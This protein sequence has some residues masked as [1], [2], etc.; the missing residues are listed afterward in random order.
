MRTINITTTILISIIVTSKLISHPNDSS[1]VL[2]FVLICVYLCSFLRV[3]LLDILSRTYGSM[4]SNVDTE[5]K[6]DNHPDHINR[7]LNSAY[8]LERTTDDCSHTA[9]KRRKSLTGTT[10]T[11][12]TNS[13]DMYEPDALTLMLFTTSLVGYL[14][15]CTHY[16]SYAYPM[17]I[18]A[19]VVLSI[20]VSSVEE[21][22]YLHINDKKSYA[23]Y[24]ISF[25]LLWV[26]VLSGMT[27]TYKFVGTYN[28]S[29]LT[30]AW[31]LMYISYTF[32]ISSSTL[33]AP[34]DKVDK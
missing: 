3:F 25:T 32:G 26:T 13:R 4:I 34:V 23:L 33:P 1:P 22:H 31:I 5:G 19:S 24:F 29:I 7:N 18:Y 17:A 8:H 10:N 14:S 16:H 20:A 15:V 30:S 6:P 27:Y 2:L 21:M 12:K 11:N 28:T 9:S